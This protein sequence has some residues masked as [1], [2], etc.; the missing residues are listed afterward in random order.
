MDLV[1]LRIRKATFDLV[2]ED[3][4]LKIFMAMNVQILVLWFVTSCISLRSFRRFGE[5]FSVHPQGLGIKKEEEGF[6]ITSVY[7]YRGKRYHN[8][9]NPNM[10]IRFPWQQLHHPFGYSAHYF[11]H[12]SPPFDP[13]MG[14]MDSVSHPHVLFR[15][16]IHYIVMG[17]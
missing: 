9:E 6:S 10:K 8:T 12:K 15:S 17:W 4:W 5:M 3:L 16:K 2:A 13:V 1:Q 14:Q 11:F 7:T